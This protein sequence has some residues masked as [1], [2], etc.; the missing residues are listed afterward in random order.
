MKLEASLGYIVKLC[1]KNKQTGNRDIISITEEQG[2]WLA[3]WDLEQRWPN[4]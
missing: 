1:L 3:D 4:Y 2:N